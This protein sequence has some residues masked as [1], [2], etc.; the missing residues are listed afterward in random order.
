MPRGYHL[1]DFERGQ[2][3]AYRDEG[4]NPTDIGKKLRRDRTTISK[5]LKDP[6]NYG[7]K[8]RPGRPR[9][10]DGRAERRILRAAGTGNLSANQIRVAQKVPL[11]T[12]SVQKIISS[13]PHMKYEKR[14]HK[15]K[16][17]PKHIKAR[18]T[19]GE[20]LVSWTTMWP[21]VLF[22]DEKKFNLDGPDGCQY[23]WRDLRKEP[24]YF[25]K[26]VQGGGSVM[27]W[28]AFGYNGKTAIAFLDGR[29][30][31]AAYQEVLQEC[32]LPN[33]RRIGGRDWIF[34]QDNAPIHT[35]RTTKEWFRQHGVRVLDWP[36]RSPDLNPI[37]NL[38][39]SLVRLVYAGGRQY[40]TVAELRLAIEATWDQIQLS[41]LQKLVD[42]MP[43]RMVQ[44]L[45]RNGNTIDY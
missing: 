31:A 24:Q 20:F 9:T 7:Q 45:K 11:T 38:W 36:A 8:K 21:T 42:S 26:R 39:G 5:F 6:E 1:T 10:L 28:A 29:Q 17:E 35:A 25:S 44:L 30:D 3:M 16:L 12:R 33:G 40:D 27:V 43:K 14:K 34:K 32:L 18:L 37:E 22:S 23:Y 13:S 4:M 15:P 19:W 41:E 2:I